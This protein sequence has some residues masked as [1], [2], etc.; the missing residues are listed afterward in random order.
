M[1]EISTYVSAAL[2]LVKTQRDKRLKTSYLLRLPASQPLEDPS[3]S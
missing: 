1:P 2:V 3:W